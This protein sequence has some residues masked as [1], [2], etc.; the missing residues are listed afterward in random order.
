MTSIHKS[1]RVLY[2]EA[3]VHLISK[4]TKIFSHFTLAPQDQSP[5][6][7]ILTALSWRP[8]VGRLALD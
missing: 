2:R 1:R 7:P 5:A 8:N 4:K 6:P 3:F